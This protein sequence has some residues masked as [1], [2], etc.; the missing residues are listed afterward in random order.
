VAFATCV[1]LLAPAACTASG[2]RPGL[3]LARV[4]PPAD[5]PPWV[6]VLG[7]VRAPGRVWIG[8]P[9][10]LYDVLVQAGGLTALACGSLRV[11]RHSGGRVF[12]FIVPIRAVRDRAAVA[13]E[14]VLVGGD[15]VFV[16]MCE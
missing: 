5:A 15:E 16:P 12:A 6:A 10:R 3:Q 2:P 11:R 7:E 14:V 1:A 13:E 4:P 8:T 9:T